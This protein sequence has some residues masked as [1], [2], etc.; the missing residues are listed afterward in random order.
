[1]FKLVYQA[2]IL[3]SLASGYIL[4]RLISFIKNKKLFFLYKLLFFIIFCAQLSYSYFAI[5]SFYNFSNFSQYQGLWGLNFLQKKEPANMVVVD[6]FNQNVSGQPVILEA[7]GDSYSEYN[8]IS[9]S[10]GL[11][12]VQGWIVHEWLWRGGYDFPKKRQADVKKIYESKD[13]EIVSSLID[14]YKVEYIIVGPQEKIKYKNI[15]DYI[16]TQLNFTKI[17]SRQDINVYK[18]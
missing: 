5:K 2:F 12:T 15:N 4:V 6:W 18:R 14:K 7:V 8:N 3:Y 11:P 9:M 1:M 17:I 16:F 13:K 10:T